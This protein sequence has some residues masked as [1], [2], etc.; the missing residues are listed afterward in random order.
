M[1]DCVPD[2]APPKNP[3]ISKWTYSQIRLKH[4]SSG[5]PQQ[6]EGK[7]SHYCRTAIW[8]PTWPNKQQP[9]EIP[10]FDSPIQLP[11]FYIIHTNERVRKFTK[12][13]WEGEKKKTPKLRYMHKN[14]NLTAQING[15]FVCL[16]WNSM[17]WKKGLHRRWGSNIIKSGW[18]RKRHSNPRDGTRR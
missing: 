3:S 11:S 15:K 2:L 6:K 17:Q 8:S 13:F 12:S 5:L 4:C 7:N 16:C 1:I 14:S 10:S 18:Y 9:Q